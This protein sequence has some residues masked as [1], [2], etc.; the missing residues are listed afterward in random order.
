MR[1]KTIKGLVQG[2]SNTPQRFPRLPD[3]EYIGK[4]AKQFWKSPTFEVKSVE[5]ATEFVF[6]LKFDI[7]ARIRERNQSAFVMLFENKK[8]HWER[9]LRS[10]YLR[11]HDQSDERMPLLARKVVYY[12]VLEA[13]RTLF[14]KAKSDTPSRR[15]LVD[16]RNKMWEAAKPEMRSAQIGRRRKAVRLAK[17]YSKLLPAVKEL[18]VFIKEQSDKWSENEKGL[19]EQIEGKFSFRGVKYC[20]RGTALNEIPEISSDR[21]K[22]MYTLVDP[23]WTARQ[24]TAGILKCE[25]D[26]RDPWSNLSSTAILDEYVPLGRKKIKDRS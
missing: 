25:E 20:T 4:M 23:K 14:R 24:L 3:A 21:G 12:T 9:L 18:R 10:A 1:K 13:L 2:K 11:A 5:G 17:R 15:E 7:P 16:E 26:E 6:T 8:V 19:R 22:K